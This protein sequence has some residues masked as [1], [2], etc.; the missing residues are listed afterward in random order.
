MTIR[1]YAKSVGFDVVGKLKYMGKWNRRTKYFADD[2][3][4]A[5]L[6]DD[7]TKEIG[8]IPNKKGC[9]LKTTLK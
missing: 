4:N 1:D 6:I 8:I 2:A 7:Y 9:Q 5:F 3:K